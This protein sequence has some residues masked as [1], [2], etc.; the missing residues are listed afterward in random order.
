MK[1]GRTEYKAIVKRNFSLVKFD[2]DGPIFA[3]VLQ[4]SDPSDSAKFRARIGH[5]HNSFIDRQRRLL[6]LLLLA[7]IVVAVTTR[8]ARMQRHHAMSADEDGTIRRY[9]KVLTIQM[10]AIGASTAWWVGGV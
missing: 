3:D 7:L 1:F 9:G 6:M 4:N 10:P 2:T 8:R 5:P